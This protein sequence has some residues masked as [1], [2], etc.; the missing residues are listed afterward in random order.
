MK[1]NESEMLSQKVER[2]IPYLR[3]FSGLPKRIFLIK[4]ESDTPLTFKLIENQNYLILYFK[5]TDCGACLEEMRHIIDSLN[6]FKSIN[7]LIA[8]DHPVLF[9][10]KYFMYKLGLKEVIWD[11]GN[12]LFNSKIEKTPLYIFIKRNKIKDIGIIAPLK[13]EGE[14]VYG[15]YAHK[16][17]KKLE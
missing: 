6:N 15:L 8:T 17:K 2:Y 13:S 5:I 3:K 12:Y 7:I 10:I 14:E 1:K 4:F 16:L 9:E 11:K